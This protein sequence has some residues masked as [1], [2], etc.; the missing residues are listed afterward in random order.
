MTV[1]DTAYHTHRPLADFTCP[2]PT[3]CTLQ[4]SPYPKCPA[5]WVIEIATCD[6]MLCAT[7]EYA[8]PAMP[9]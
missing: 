3:S 4:Y 7:N 2:P 1:P 6:E 9:W 5:P 8:L